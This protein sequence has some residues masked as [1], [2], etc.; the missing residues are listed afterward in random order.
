MN[1]R[2]RDKIAAYD[3]GRWAF[4]PSSRPYIYYIE[5]EAESLGAV[6]ILN[7]ITRVFAEFGVSLLQV[8]ISAPV[9]RTENR[10]KSVRIII[11]ADLAGKEEM[12]SVILDKIRGIDFVVDAWFEPPIVDGLAVDTYSFPLMM[13]GERAVIFRRKVYE[14]LLKRG[15][16]VYGTGYAQ[17][18]YIVGIETGRNVYM[19]H[20]KYTGEEPENLLKFMAAFFQMLGY[21]RLEVVYLDDSARRAVVRVFDSAEC[22]LF[23]G[24]QPPSPRGAFIRGLIVGWLAARWGVGDYLAITA[25]EMKCIAKGDQ[26]CEYHI[27]TER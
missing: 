11:V 5:L 27:K 16:E 1:Q 4:V 6:G 24:A 21:G 17:L 26:Y 8:K 15:V 3:V 18:L 13:G 19:D 2:T 14:G 10:A 7:S 25:Q 9:R 23:K 12:A 22:E 20:T